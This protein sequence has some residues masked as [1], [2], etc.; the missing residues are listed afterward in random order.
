MSNLFSLN[1]CT[2]LV[3]GGFSG[4]GR[5]FC[6]TLLQAGAN[7]AIAG[8]RIEQGHDAAQAL[9]EWADEQGHCGR[10]LAFS[11]DVKRRE[12]VE[13]C[14][15]EVRERL[16]QA[17]ILVNNAGVATTTPVLETTDADWNSVLDVNLTG[18]W[19]VAQVFA[20]D[21]VAS[22]MAGRIINVGSILGLRVAQ[23]VPAYAAS[24]AGLLHLTRALAIELARHSIRVNALAPGYF[25]TDLNQEFFRSE[26]GQSLIRRIPERR[27]GNLG[28]LDGPLLLLASE[29]GS[30]MNGAVLTVDGGHSTNSL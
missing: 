11:L 5:H 19:R 20:Q 21:L 13:A 14:L 12:S 15:R 1:A 29:A 17:T 16:G 2:A 8:R 24:K 4:L 10:V 3:T 18:A 7:V 25:Q 22:D 30:F 26:A 9:Q 6:A 27:L 28:E 23:Q